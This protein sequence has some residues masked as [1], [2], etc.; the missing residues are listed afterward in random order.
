MKH[1]TKNIFNKIKQNKFKIGFISAAMATIIGCSIG[2]GLTLNVAKTTQVDKPIYTPEL[3]PVKPGELKFDQTGK[4]IVPIIIDEKNPNAD[5]EHKVDKTLTINNLDKKEF[6]KSTEN[7][8]DLETKYIELIP[9]ISDS[10][11]A[12]YLEKEIAISS[13]VKKFIDYYLPNNMIAEHSNFKFKDFLADIQQSSFLYTQENSLS[14]QEIHDLLAFN[15]I[16]FEKEYNTIVSSADQIKTRGGGGMNLPGV[17]PHELSKPDL[18]NDK[19]KTTYQEGVNLYKT[20]IENRL[21]IEVVYSAALLAISIAAFALAF[22]TF[23]ASLLLAAVD[24]VFC[25]IS[26]VQAIDEYI[27]VKNNLWIPLN[28][29]KSFLLKYFI[30]SKVESMQWF[31]IANFDNIT[32]SK[33]IKSLFDDFIGSS[34]QW[35]TFE[36]KAREFSS[37]FISDQ[38]ITKIKCKV[39]LN[40]IS[41]SLSL[42]SLALLAIKEEMLKRLDLIS[43]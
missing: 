40:I 18:P 14:M 6:F 30:L 41:L 23:G 4:P 3:A 11:S 13:K 20:D 33:V 10:F 36:N 34:N 29:F 27:V 26:V 5:Y 37:G 22:V 8:K 17:V 35:K 12:E 1:T 7:K 38:T 42:L 31:I 25:T 28:D 24:L 9:S 21:L 32:D 16:N 2:L 39:N 15:G 19:T 43:V